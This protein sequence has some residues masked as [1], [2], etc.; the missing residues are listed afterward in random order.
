[1]ENTVLQQLQEECARANALLVAVSKTKPVSAIEELYQLGQR[2]FGENYVQEL[3]EKSASLPGDIRWHFIGH[4]QRNKVKYIAPFVG[5][6]H[7]VDSE[8]LLEEIHKQALRH[9]R[10]IDVL[11]QVYVAREETKYGLE[12]TELLDLA[13]RIYARSGAFAQVRIRGVMGMAS[14][15]DDQVQVRRELREIRGVFDRLRAQCP[16]WQD[17]C[18]IC[19]MGMSGDYRVAL[20]EGS[21]LVRIGSMLFGKRG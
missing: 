17:F 5:L 3:V 15:T 18:T 2:D 14:F 1:M 8:A 19:S 21:T 13:S 12:P 16:E 10:V 20:E 11:L 4:L 6:I 9:N 7:A